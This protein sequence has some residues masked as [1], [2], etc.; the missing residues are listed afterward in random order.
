MNQ[1]TKKKRRLVLTCVVAVGVSL[2]AALWGGSAAGNT[3]SPASAAAAGGPSD[4]R[5]AFQN[6]CQIFTVNPDGAALVQVTHYR[7]RCAQLPSWSPDATRIAYYLFS[8]SFDRA[9]IYTSNADGSDPRLVTTDGAGFYDVS[10]DYTP[11]GRRIVYER[12][13]SVPS[14]SCAIYSVALNG[15]DRH[16]LTKYRDCDCEA[17]ARPQV[18]PDGE[19]VSFTR[20]DYRGYAIQVWL[21]RIDGSDQHLLTRPGQTATGAHWA[22]DGRTVY[23]DKGGHEGFGGQVLKMP[24]G[25]GHA[26]QLTFSPW[27]NG[28]CCI[29]VAP[30][31]DRVAFIS[32]R[33]Y[34]DACCNE[35]FLMHADG[36]HQ[37]VVM[38][39]SNALFPDWGTAPLQ[40]G[41]SR[42]VAP[43]SAAMRARAARAQDLFGGLERGSILPQRISGETETHPL[44]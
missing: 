44:G 36:S 39:G 6:A 26:T 9:S 12:C 4:G 10:P 19:W 30:E 34:P 43:P 22:P 8:S 27:P 13:R 17:A 14:L 1:L 38:P 41:S 28:N 33:D 29:S 2:S 24:A 25:G 7:S 11:D 42:S 18:S 21:M 15:T 16:Q 40:S 32:D 31:G 23:F 37:H 20:V 5:I 35:L 3:P